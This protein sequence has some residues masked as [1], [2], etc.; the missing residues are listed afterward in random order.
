VTR[1]KPFRS[2]AKATLGSGFRNHLSHRSPLLVLPP[3]IH[4]FVV[5][6]QTAEQMNI[7]TI[8]SAHFRVIA[9]DGTAPDGR[10]R[11]FSQ[12]AAAKAFANQETMNG[13][14]ESMW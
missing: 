3:T 14:P 6:R 9:A 12:R 10:H 8:Y 7:T 1:R 5:D 4:F 11:Q 2:Y 13:E